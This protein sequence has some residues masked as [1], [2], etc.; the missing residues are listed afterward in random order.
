ME[1]AEDLFREAAPARLRTVDILGGGERA[2][3]DALSGDRARTKILRTSPFGLIEMTRKRRTPQLED[4]FQ[5]TSSTRF[6]E[7]KKLLNL[8]LS[9][10]QLRETTLF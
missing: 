4:R 8:S 1:A 3:R 5:G 7:E 10:P 2:L 6:I 9:I